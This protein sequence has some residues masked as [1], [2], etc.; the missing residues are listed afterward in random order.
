LI[1]EFWRSPRRGKLKDQ[2]AETSSPPGNGFGLHDMGG[3]V[4]DWT[5][6][7][8]GPYPS[9]PQV[10]PVGPSSAWGRVFRSGCWHLGPWLS[11]VSVRFENEPNGMRV[12]DTG[13]RVVRDP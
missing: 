2:V 13:M 4:L 12:S 8:F 7:W 9:A 10:D 3:N 5:N 6:D 1:E 11:R